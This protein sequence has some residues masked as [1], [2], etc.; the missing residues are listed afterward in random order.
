MLRGS[1]RDPFKPLLMLLLILDIVAERNRWTQIRNLKSSWSFIEVGIDIHLFIIA[2][3][4][5]RI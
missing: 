1:G 5:V 2:L 4:I 3:D